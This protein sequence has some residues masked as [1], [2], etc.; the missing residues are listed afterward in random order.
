MEI[1]TKEVSHGTKWVGKILWVCDYRRPDLD[2][3]PIRNVPPTKVILLS[4]ENL[5]KGK[6]VYYTENHFVKLTAKG[7]PSSTVIPLFDNTGY[8]SF[9]GTPLSVFD[10]EQECVEFFNKQA[11]K[12]IHDLDERIKTI[13]D[14][15]NEQRNYVQNQ[16]IKM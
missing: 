4:N 1:L 7:M 5:P 3:K 14:S 10:N 8:R 6:K 13:L 16:K 12:I 2:K 11:D 15:L 9:T